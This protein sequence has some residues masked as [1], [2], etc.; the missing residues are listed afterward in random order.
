MAFWLGWKGYY[1]NALISFHAYAHTCMLTRTD[2][3]KSDALSYINL[4]LLLFAD[5]KEREEV[6]VY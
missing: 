6:H 5:I 4:T 1:W 3:F 2:R